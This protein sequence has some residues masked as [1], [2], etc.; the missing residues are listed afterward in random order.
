MDLNKEIKETVIYI[1]IGLALASV[2]NLGLGFALGAEKPLMAVVSSSMEDTFYKGDLVVVRGIKPEEIKI[3]DIVV[4]HNLCRNIEV[5]HRVVDIKEESVGNFRCSTGRVVPGDGKVG[6]RFYTKGDNKRTNPHTDQISRIAP[7]LK[8]EWIKGNVVL[9]IPKLGWFKV[10]LT[11]SL[12]SYGAF[13]VALF[14]ILIIGLMMFI[15]G[16]GGRGKKSG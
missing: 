12:S 10:I 3:G 1:V 11:E 7:P 6:L 16:L 15:S 14:A 4:Y 8:G 13:N 9:V 2:I 5:V